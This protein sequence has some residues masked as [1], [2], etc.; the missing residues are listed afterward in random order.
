MLPD[1]MRLVTIVAIF[2]LALFGVAEH[3]SAAVFRHKTAVTCKPGHA[4]LVSANS[5][6]QLYKATV[7][8]GLPEFLGIYGC[9]YGHKPVFLGPVPYASSGGA[10][11]IAFETLAGSV[12]AYEEANIGGYESDRTERWVIVRDLRNGNIL[13]RVPTGTSPKS[14]PGIVGIGNVEGSTLYWTQDGHSFSATL[15]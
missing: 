15:K 6:A 12:V 14:K 2:A 4:R 3:T 5:Q 7:P 1:R 11:G 13:H 8:H 10:G 9:T